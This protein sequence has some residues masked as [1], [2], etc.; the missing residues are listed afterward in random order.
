MIGVADSEMGET[1]KAVVVP[2]HGQSITLDDVRDF[3]KGRVSSYKAPQY[4]AITG[5]L[6]RKSHGKDP[7]ERPAQ[8]PRSA[9]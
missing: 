6:P 2:A 3:C 9:G 8:A 4:L 1:V 5:Q 7:Q